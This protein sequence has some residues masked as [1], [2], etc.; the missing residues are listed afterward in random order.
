M[1]DKKKELL[2]ELLKSETAQQLLTEQ[3]K[4]ASDIKFGNSLD[5]PVFEAL[6]ALAFA[7]DTGKRD[8]A[9]VRWVNQKLE[10]IGQEDQQ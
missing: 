2:L 3:G 5:S 10:A 4:K 9:L 6:K 8:T 1:V 7:T